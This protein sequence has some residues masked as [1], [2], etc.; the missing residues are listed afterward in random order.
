MSSSSRPAGF[1]AVVFGLLAL[2]AIPVGIVLAWLL[3]SVNLLP[4]LIVS[5][6]V[7]FVLSLCG[8]SAVRRARFKVE[9]SVFR[10]GDR[11]AKLGKFLVWAGLY[12]A[13]VGALALG[14][15]GAIRSQS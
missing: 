13:L 6:P 1:T 10:V 8:I 5:V 14:F 3:P 11:T 7:A 4:A 15:Y 9:R 2:A 12:F